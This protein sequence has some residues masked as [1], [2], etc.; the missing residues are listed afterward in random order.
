MGLKRA[1]AKGE[2]LAR[3]NRQQVLFRIE[4]CVRDVDEVALAQRFRQGPKV[5]HVN[6]AFCR[7]AVQ[8][9]VADGHAPVRRHVQS[10]ADLFDVLPPAFGA[11]VCRQGRGR[12]LPYSCLDPSQDAKDAEMPRSV[13]INFR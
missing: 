9:Q 5:V 1:A 6:R 12:G 13:Q 2:P 11:T 8:G 7:I 4:F 3:N 10:Q